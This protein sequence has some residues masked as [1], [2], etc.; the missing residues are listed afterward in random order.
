M[1]GSGYATGYAEISGRKSIGTLDPI[2]VARQLNV[3]ALATSAINRNAMILVTLINLIL[4][5]E[6]FASILNDHCVALRRTRYSNEKYVSHF[7]DL[8]DAGVIEKVS[9]DSISYFSTYFSVPK[10]GPEDRSIFN[11]RALSRLFRSPT[12]CN[13]P[14]IPRVIREMVRLNERHE[15][16]YVVVGDFRHWFHQIEMST[17]VRGW[18]GLAWRCKGLTHVA[19]WCS[20]PMG[21]SWSPTIAQACAWSLLTHHEL[22]EDVYTPMGNPENL[23]Q[24]VPVI[25]N[26]HE[27]GW[28]SVY[29][30]NYI[31]ITTSADA[32]VAMNKRNLDG[33]QRLL[34]NY[35]L[36]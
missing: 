29:Y 1:A 6:S 11:G 34:S 19:Q 3:K 36:I 16:L 5:E 9:H 27:V 4:T 23:S 30:D 15:G 2:R 21:W 26:H 32:M 33:E 7:E 18:F 35:L 25:Y 28:M 22:D 13:I 8:E 10:D 20:L 12:P 24:F 31:V 17:S 14:D